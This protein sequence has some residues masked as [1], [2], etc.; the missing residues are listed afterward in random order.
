[1]QIRLK[2]RPVSYTHLDV[3]KRQ[4]LSNCPR[5][6]TMTFVHPTRLADAQVMWFCM[7]LMS[8]VI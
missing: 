8:Y 2:Q 7:S 3:Y 4:V 6:Q 5:G 1:M